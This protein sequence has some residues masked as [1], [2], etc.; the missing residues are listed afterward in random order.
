MSLHLCQ[1]RSN[2]G[3]AADSVALMLFELSI[4]KVSDHTKPQMKLRR[5]A[6]NSNRIDSSEP[7]A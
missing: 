5:V 3:F 7:G 2:V 6:A 4:G 1:L